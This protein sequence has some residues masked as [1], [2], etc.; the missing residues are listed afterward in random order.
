MLAWRCPHPAGPR[1]HGATEQF[2]HSSQPTQGRGHVKV[3]LYMVCTVGF[4]GTHLRRDHPHANLLSCC[5]RCC[6]S[7]L[8]IC[9]CLMWPPLLALLLPL[10][11]LLLLLVGRAPHRRHCCC[12]CL[13]GPQHIFRSAAVDAAACCCRRRCCCHCPGTA[14]GA[15]KVPVCCCVRPSALAACIAAHRPAPHVVHSAAGVTRFTSWLADGSW[16]TCRCIWRC[17]P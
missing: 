9:H 1:R 15:C 3:A 8:R 7:C 2:S 16:N 12:F 4:P 17:M 11:V 5:C 13:Q 14:A 10:H 6:C